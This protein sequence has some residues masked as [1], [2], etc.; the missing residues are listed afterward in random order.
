MVADFNADGI[1]VL[2]IHPRLEHG[3]RVFLG[4][5]KGHWRDSS[6]GLEMPKGSCGG[7]IQTGDA[8]N[9]GKPDLIVADHCNGIYVYLNDGRGNWTPATE[10]LSP[11]FSTEKRVKEKFGDGS[12]GVES[13]AVG[14]INGDGKL[15]LVVSMTDV[16]GYAVFLGDGTG[17][18]WKEVKEHGLPNGWESSPI[19]VY[20]GGFSYDI[21][22]RDVNGDGKLDVVTAYYTG[23]RVFWGD[24]TGHFVDHSHGLRAS[25]VGGIYTRIASGDL[26]GDGRPDLVVANNFNGAEVYFQNADGTWQGPV[27][28]MPD[29][30]GGARA[31]AIGDIDGDG[32]ND[33]VIGGSFEQSPKWE[34]LPHGLWVRWGNGKGGF[35]DRPTTNL[36]AIGMEVIM[37][38][39][40]ADVDGDGRPDIV[41]SSGGFTG[42]LGPGPE[43][44]SAVA[45]KLPKQAELPVPRVQVWRNDS[46][47]RGR[48][49]I[50][51]A[52]AKRASVK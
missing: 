46:G 40:I 34:V 27:D 9:D 41:V 28:G 49:S 44:P 38:L 51:G 22:L 18:N 37:G 23:P 3:A 39:R 14:D 19:D 1:S 5:G 35:S 32:N 15:D 4:D 29:L 11:E 47:A 42:R 12:F 36:P 33:I 10:H 25:G 7:A 31:V 20:L 13:V 16:G 17:R 21:Q 50:D 43:L 2:P 24:G 30:Q 48:A 6:K 45:A 8:N 26:N 52:A